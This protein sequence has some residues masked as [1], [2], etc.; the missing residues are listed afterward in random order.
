M[1]MHQ[2]ARENNNQVFPHNSKT[3]NSDYERL[4]KQPCSQKSMN[5]VSSGQHIDQQEKKKQKQCTAMFTNQEIS[6][7]MRQ[8]S[9]SEFQTKQMACEAPKII[10]KYFKC[11]CIALPLFLSFTCS[12]STSIFSKHTVLRGYYTRTHTQPVHPGCLARWDLIFFQ[13]R[14][15]IHIY[16]LFFDKNEIRKKK[17]FLIFNCFFYL[18][19]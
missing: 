16:S 11:I 9:N 1:D 15:Y 4:S 14:L 18:F 10:L 17:Q 12:S 13:L 3:Y 19:R 2:E 8:K 6:R 5:T 7:P